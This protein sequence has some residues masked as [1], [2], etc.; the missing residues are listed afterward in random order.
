[1]P[2]IIRFF[3]F[4]IVI[5]YVVFIVYIYFGSFKLFMI[6]K[7]HMFLVYLIKLEFTYE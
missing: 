2:E 6:M 7:K 3:P 5:N 4:N 1:M